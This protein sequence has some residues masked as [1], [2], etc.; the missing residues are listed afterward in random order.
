MII[1]CHITL[2][3]NIRKIYSKIVLKKLHYSFLY[4]D[5]ELTLS[6]YLVNKNIEKEKTRHSKNYLHCSAYELLRARCNERY[7]CCSSKQNV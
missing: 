5:R 2:E 7:N 3:W 1:Y 6:P 4:F